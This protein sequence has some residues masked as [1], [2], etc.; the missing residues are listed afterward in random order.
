MALTRRQARA[1]LV[2]LFD[3]DLEQELAAVIANWWG[4]E[5]QKVLKA[6]AAR[7]GRQA[8]R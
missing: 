3:R 5:A 7:L 4:D 2:Q 8:A 1:D 6:L